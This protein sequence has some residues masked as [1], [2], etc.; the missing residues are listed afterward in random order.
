MN[1]GTDQ[2]T[3]NAQLFVALSRVNP[4]ALTALLAV[5]ANPN[6]TAKYGST[7]LDWAD[8]VHVAT[9]L[10]EAMAASLAPVASKSASD[11]MRSPS[12]F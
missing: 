7:P 6:A 4:T 3:L 8:N 12:P 5:G 9:V 10:R 1:T 2:A 11:G